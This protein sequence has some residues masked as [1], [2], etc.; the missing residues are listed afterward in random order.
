[1][2]FMSVSCMPCLLTH[3]RQLRVLVMTYNATR[4]C[5]SSGSSKRLR[6]RC[7][8]CFRI[9]ALTPAE[10]SSLLSAPCSVMIGACVLSFF[11]TPAKLSR[12]IA[13]SSL[14]VRRVFSTAVSKMCTIFTK[15]FSNISTSCSLFSSALDERSLEDLRPAF[16]SGSCGISKVI[17]MISAQCCRK[18]PTTRCNGFRTT[19]FTLE[20][21]TKQVMSMMSSTENMRQRLEIASD[22]RTTSRVY[23]SST[24]LYSTSAMDAARLG[25]LKSIGGSCSPGI[26][27]PGEHTKEP[28]SLMHS[29]NGP[30]IKF[31]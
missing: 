16:S 14:L 20:F 18:T 21:I 15:T 7:S 22:C 25:S 29:P 1:M 9:S 2:N 23:R 30:Y 31:W 12:N 17:F 8:N 4:R 24:C 5:I 19:L 28:L 26:V 10:W 27:P 11:S 13:S 3:R 6:L